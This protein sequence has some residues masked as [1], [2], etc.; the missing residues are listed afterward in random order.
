[1][2]AWWRIASAQS[3]LGAC[4]LVMPQRLDYTLAEQNLSQII[5]CRRIAAMPKI[6]IVGAGSHVFARRL[7]ADVLTWPAL[8]DSTIALMD[9]DQESLDTMAALANKMVKQQGVGA[10]IEATTDLE[11]ALTD[12]DYVSVSI[13]VGSSY[14]HVAI[15]AKYGI[16][17]SVGDTMGPGGVFYFLKNA[18]AVINIAQTMERVCPKA[19][20][21]NYT[22][23]MVMLSWAIKDLTDIRYVGLCHSVQGTAQSMAEYINVPFEDVS[24][25]AAGINHMAWFLKYHVNGEDAYPMLFE[26]MQNP[27][28]YNRDIVKFEVMKHF[29]AFVS[30]SSIHMSEYVPYFRRTQELIDR[31][32]HEAMWGVGNRQM[33]REE[34]MR[35]YAERR[36]EA[37]REMHEL[38]SGDDPVPD[39]W[40]E[41][42]HEFFSRILN[43]SETNVPYT[44]NGNVANTGLI[45]NFPNNVVVEVPIVTDAMGLHPCHVGALPP[46]LAALNSSNLYVQ[47]LAVKGFIEQNRECIYQA[48][49]VDPLT[50]SLLSLA[51]IRQMVDEMFEAEAEYIAF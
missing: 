35:M 36:A 10:R 16:M 25:W 31:H 15:P 14:Q 32:T 33:S 24:Y 4:L 29:G 42:S 13:R 8:R 39:E 50:A 23:P 51:E 1:L 19:L 21:L 47:E 12:A 17:H 26:A 43:A 22:N 20:M 3:A 49:Q 18:P 46:A 7:I 45:T 34:R 41:R 27:D 37:D 28:V 30:E 2:A 5:Q 38:V 44:F 6:A 9:I 11:E 48:I 40:L